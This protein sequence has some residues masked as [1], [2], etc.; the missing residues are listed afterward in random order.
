MPSCGIGAVDARDGDQGDG[1]QH[2]G[3]AN[4]RRGQ[5]HRFASRV[6]NHRALEAKLDDIEERLSQR[7]SDPALQ[8]GG[9]AAVGAFKG[10]PK[11]QGE[12]PAREEQYRDEYG[13]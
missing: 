13:V 5:E 10:E 12:E 7:R 11:C 1:D 8:A 2:G 4:E 9:D 3:R 6:R